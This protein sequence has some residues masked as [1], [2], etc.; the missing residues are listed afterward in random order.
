VVQDSPQGMIL[1]KKILGRKFNKHV[2][3]TSKM[4][5]RNNIFVRLRNIENVV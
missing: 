1:N 4:M 5:N 2:V 3:V